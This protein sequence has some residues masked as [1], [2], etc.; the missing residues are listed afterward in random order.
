MCIF[1]T[2]ILAIFYKL[3]FKLPVPLFFSFMVAKEEK[4][5]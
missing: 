2:K 4:K 1:K 3:H 5:S